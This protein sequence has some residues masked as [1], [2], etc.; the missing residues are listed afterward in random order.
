M[1][2]PFQTGL[3]ESTGWAEPGLLIQ[4]DRFGLNS[5]DNKKHGS[6][7]SV[8]RFRVIIMSALKFW[9]TGKTIA[10]G[11]DVNPDPVNGFL[12]LQ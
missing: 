3:V 11:F 12:C 4:V 5:G 2:Q 1:I 10:G 9:K 6:C 7:I 8:H